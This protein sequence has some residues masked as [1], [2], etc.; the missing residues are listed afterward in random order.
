ML[1]IS[2]ITTL[3]STGIA[4]Y[5]RFLFALCEELTPHWISNRKP[6]RLRLEAKRTSNWLSP[7]LL[8]PRA[9]LQITKYHST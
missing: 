9:A 1:L 5:L 4:F 6:A 7:E 3:C 2:V 8:H